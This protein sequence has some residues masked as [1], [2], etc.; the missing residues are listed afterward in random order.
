M[1][2]LLEQL[3]W[4]SATVRSI[5]GEIAIWGS[6]EHLLA[7]AVDALRMANWQRSSDKKIPRPEPIPRP[8]TSASRQRPR[9]SPAETSARLRDLQRRS[10]RRRA[11]KGG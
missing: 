5:H 10:A 7:M 1:G 3:P 9:L 11:Q 2:S 8:G 6:V 4:D